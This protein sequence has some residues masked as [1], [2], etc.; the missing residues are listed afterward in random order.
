MPLRFANNAVSVL[1]TSVLLTDTTIPLTASHGSRFPTLSLPGDVFIATIQNGA[2]FEIVRVTG[3]SGDV[4]TVVRGQEGTSAQTWAAGSSVNMRVTKGTME[5]LAQ[6]EELTAPV[7]HIV[8]WPTN[9][10]PLN[11]LFCNGA[12]VSRVTHANLFAVIG[13]QY[14]AG[15]GTTTFNL[16]DLRGRVPVGKDDMGG[17]AAVNRVT[18]VIS[19]LNGTLL[20]AAG[21]NQSMQ[22]HTHTVND[23]G[24]AHSVYDPGH[25]HFGTVTGLVAGAS[26]G[27]VVVITGGAN[28]ASAATGISIYAA[29]TGVTNANTGAG[30][31]Q[32]VQ[33]SIIMNYIIYAGP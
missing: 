18:A 9:T 3:R 22:T 16:P 26:G 10:A 23:P 4:L 1:P 2:V 17:A 31:S 14:G 30:T 7:G 20:G 21:G 6:R 8:I 24:H 15:N 11:F 13:V 29:P 28:T 12:A 5:A 32:N 19:G 25:V 33:P 27:A